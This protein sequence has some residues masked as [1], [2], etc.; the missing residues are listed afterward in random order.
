[1]RRAILFGMAL[2]G[3]AALAAL[4]LAGFVRLAP[5]DPAR[6]HTDPSAG[7]A[8]PN[9]EVAEAVLPLAPD[10]ALA[11]LDAVALATPRTRRL[12]GSPEEGRITWVSR[13]RLM[14]FPDYTTAAAAAV[15]GGSRIVVFAR[16]RF[17]RD[18]LGVNAAR[19]GRWIAALEGAGQGGG[20]PGPAR[21]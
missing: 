1:M 10:A 3:L 5:S 19:T 8:G 18:D 20:A 17:G 13:S 7:A 15:P 14:G 16:A 6:W 4:A 11:A 2:A 21:P 9:S 12:A